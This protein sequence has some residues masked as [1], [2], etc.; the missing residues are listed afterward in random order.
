MPVGRNELDDVFTE[1]GRLL[2]ILEDDV[3]YT[4]EEIG[5]ML[6]EDFLFPGEPG[7]EYVDIARAIYGIAWVMANRDDLD[8]GVKGDVVYYG[9]KPI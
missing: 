5:E 4:V 6:T 9:K 3:F 7:E 8:M 1:H 2:G